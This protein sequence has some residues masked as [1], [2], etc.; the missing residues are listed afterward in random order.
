LTKK[1]IEE[2]RILQGIDGT[3]SNHWPLKGK[4]HSNNATQTT[5]ESP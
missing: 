4:S 3:F 1:G 5:G 2:G